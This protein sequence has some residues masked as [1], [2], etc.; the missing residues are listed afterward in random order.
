[1]THGPFFS[2]VMQSVLFVCGM[3]LL[4]VKFIIAE[5]ALMRGQTDVSDSS[6]LNL[7]SPVLK[8]PSDVSGS[9]S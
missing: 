5:V 3:K 2:D 4:W 1:M 9:C 6:S 7:E 8:T